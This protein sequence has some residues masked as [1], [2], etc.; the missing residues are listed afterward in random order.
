LFFYA[1]TFIH[2]HKIDKLTPIEL[3]SADEDRGG[4]GEIRSKVEPYI[5]QRPQDFFQE[6]NDLVLHPDLY[7]QRSASEAELFSHLFEL[8][9]LQPYLAKTLQQVEKGNVKPAWEI[10]QAFMPLVD[11]VTK[12]QNA[13]VASR[14]AGEDVLMGLMCGLEEFAWA[15]VRAAAA[16]RGGC[17]D[18]G[19][20]HGSA[21]Y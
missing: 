2:G 17:G 3:A 15:L 7:D 20:Q 10:A 21:D 19:G 12:S 6:T 4:L 13:V 18:E 16:H 8:S 1:V 9:G 5:R 11:C 14:Q